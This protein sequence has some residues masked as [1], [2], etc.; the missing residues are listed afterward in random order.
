MRRSLVEP[1]LAQMEAHPTVG[2]QL[3]LLLLGKVAPWVHVPMVGYYWRKYH[4]QMSAKGDIR[5]QLDA[6][7]K[8]ARVYVKPETQDVTAAPVNTAAA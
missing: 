5:T 3:L 4:T 2:D 1:L 7:F 6:A 8:A